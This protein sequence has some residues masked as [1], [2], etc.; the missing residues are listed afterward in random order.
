MSSQT[1]YSLTSCVVSSVQSLP[2]DPAHQASVTKS[3]AAIKAW[4]F[5]S[6][7][8]SLVKKPSP[9]SPRVCCECIWSGLIA[10]KQ[11]G[12]AASCSTAPALLQNRPRRCLLQTQ[13]KT[14]KADLVCFVSH[15][16]AGRWFVHHRM[17]V[18]A[19]SWPSCWW[20]H[21]I[22]TSLQDSSHGEEMCNGWVYVW[23]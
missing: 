8:E 13:Q 16:S 11:F 3:F 20:S 6:G 5:S 1:N 17:D 7:A 10:G 12:N 19:T 21:E 9:S 22:Q 18:F 4:S 23:S 2:L 14:C 15:P